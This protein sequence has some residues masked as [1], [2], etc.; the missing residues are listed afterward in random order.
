[1]LFQIQPKILGR[2]LGFLLVGIGSLVQSASGDNEY[3]PLTVDYQR[4]V[5]YRNRPKPSTLEGA[6]FIEIYRKIKK[7]SI[8]P[9]FTEYYIGLRDTRAPAKDLTHSLTDYSIPS[10]SPD[11]QTLAYFDYTEDSKYRLNAYDLKTRKSAIVFEVADGQTC[12][13]VWMKDNTLFV[14]FLTLE[15]KHRSFAWL[16]IDG[17]VIYSATVPI[18]I[19]LVDVPAVAYTNN[20]HQYFRYD[21]ISGELPW[22]GC[23][24]QTEFIEYNPSKPVRVAILDKSKQQPSNSSEHNRVEYTEIKIPWEDVSVGKNGWKLLP[25]KL[26]CEAN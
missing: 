25:K 4:E 17:T 16:Q 18:A 21:N 6:P 7:F 19:A 8:L 26:G 5:I 1:M 15:Q 11:G 14:Q 2:L 24:A 9:R 22:F 23:S 20:G 12:Y 13:Y 3:R 10:L